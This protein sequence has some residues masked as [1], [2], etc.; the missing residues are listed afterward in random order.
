[1]RY[2]CPICGYVYDEKK[3]G[4][5]FDQ[6]PDSWLCPLCGAE[7]SVF[8]PQEM[9]ND[10]SPSV[11][12]ILVDSDANKL[13]PGE[14]AA[15]FSNLARGCEKQYKP[16]EQAL[17]LEL[18]DYYT[19]AMAPLDTADESV[20]VGHIQDD[21]TQHYPSARAVATQAADR[22]TLRILTWGEKV[23]RSL[24][25]LLKR[26]AREGTAFL[27]QNDLWVCSVCG[28]LYVGPSAP[29]LC[30]VCKVPDWKFERIE[31]RHSV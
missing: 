30:P 1:M 29:K 7:K 18:A 19:R 24:E 31:G 2:V 26:Y 27:E 11:E 17:F 4:V 13:T 25:S 21:L 16:E 23:T 14:L 28:F 3:E 10:P 5:P 20:L 9:Q 12:P 22:G 15:L 6:L 8:S